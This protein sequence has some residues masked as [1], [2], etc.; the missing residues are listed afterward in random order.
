MS[1]TRKKAKERK[2]RKG[3]KGKSTYLGRASSIGYCGTDTGRERRP[4][5]KLQHAQNLGEATTATMR[6]PTSR[7][8]RVERYGAG[9]GNGDATGEGRR[10]VRKQDMRAPRER[11][12]HSC[13]RRTQRGSRSGSFQAYLDAGFSRAGKEDQCEENIVDSSAEDMAPEWRSCSQHRP[14]VEVDDPAG[15]QLRNVTSEKT[16]I[17]RRSARTSK[18][19]QTQILDLERCH[20]AFEVLQLQGHGTQGR[21]MKRGAQ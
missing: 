5:G 12:M 20:S 21:R 8:G 16:K 4:C 17:R 19:N 18:S 2:G 14:D 6:S 13:R 15:E 9:S 7:T 3:R 1:M 10:T 11:G